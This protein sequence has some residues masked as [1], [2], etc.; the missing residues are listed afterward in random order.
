MYIL[1]IVV[2]YTYYTYTSCEGSVMHPFALFGYV[3]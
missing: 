1:M 3:L 2:Y